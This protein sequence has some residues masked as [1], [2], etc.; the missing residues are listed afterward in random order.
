M[1]LRRIDDDLFDELVYDGRCQFQRDV[2]LEC[3]QAVTETIRSDVEGFQED[4]LHC[5]RE[6]QEKSIRED[7]RRLA[8]AKKRLA[9][10]ETDLLNPLGSLLLRRID[11]DLF[12][13]LVYD[14]RRPA[15]CGNS[16]LLPLTLATQ[17]FSDLS[18]L[19]HKGTHM[20]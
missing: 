14:G 16:S 11:D 9:G 17:G 18:L 13:E 1:L 2:V 5:R 8:Q 7:K 3:I 15:L 6:D 20:P 10:I 19:C 12:D 4:W